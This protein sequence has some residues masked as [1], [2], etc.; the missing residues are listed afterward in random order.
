MKLL[1]NRVLV[2]KPDSKKEEVTASGLIMLEVSK[3]E[4]WE[5]EVLYVGSGYRN[6]QGEF[7]PM[8]I[9]VGDIA[10]FNSYSAVETEIDGVV[11]LMLKEHDILGTI[12]KET[13]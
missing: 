3:S 6:P 9:K 12:E 7:I 4:Y 5:C 11:Y 13:V 1:G 10:Y 2:Q 8:D